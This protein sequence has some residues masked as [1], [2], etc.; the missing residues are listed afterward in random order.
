MILAIR[1]HQKVDRHTARQR[2]RE[3]LV[4]VGIPSPDERLRAYPHQFSGG[5][6]QRVAIAITIL[7]QPDL[8]IADEL[9][10][11]LDVTIQNQIIHEIQALPVKTATDQY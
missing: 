11:A 10:T 6:C 9:T 5:M 1:A 2:A 7:Y 3:A 8:I 4:M